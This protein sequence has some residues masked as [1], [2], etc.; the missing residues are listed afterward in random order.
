MVKWVE[1]LDGLWQLKQSRDC[2]FLFQLSNTVK[3]RSHLRWVQVL[4]KMRTT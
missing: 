2:E 4:K 1:P 3:M